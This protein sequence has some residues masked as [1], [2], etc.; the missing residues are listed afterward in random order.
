MPWIRKRDNRA[1]HAA[2]RALLPTFVGLVDAHPAH[3]LD[4]G[5]ALDLQWQLPESLL[6]KADRMSMAASIELRCPFLDP[7]VAE[8]AGRIAPEVRIDPRTAMGKRP[9]HRLIARHLPNEADRKKQG[10]VLPL[11]RWLRGPLAAD[12]RARLTSESSQFVA[13]VGREGAAAWCD[14]FQ[15]GGGSA[16][17]TYALWL[18]ERWRSRQN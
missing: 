1:L 18:Y 9:L 17:I 8:V 6:V 7:V 3:P 14:E 4:V 13:L 15:S 16:H 10:F 11:G 2:W 12:V 5:Q